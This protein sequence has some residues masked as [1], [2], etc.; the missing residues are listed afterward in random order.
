[1][2]C[3]VI[4]N[5]SGSSQDRPRVSQGLPGRY[6]G[7]QNLLKICKNL[8]LDLKDSFVMLPSVPKS[9]QGSPRRQSEAT[10]YAKWQVYVPKIPGSACNNAKNLQTWSN[11]QWSG[12]GGRGRKLKQNIDWLNKIHKGFHRISKDFIRFY[13]ILGIFWSF[14][15]VFG[16]FWLKYNIKLMK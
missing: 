15:N 9:T 5:V 10:N 6:N 2:S 1:M 14:F 7:H 16:H 3:L 12:A 13:R 8:G 11:E 4:P